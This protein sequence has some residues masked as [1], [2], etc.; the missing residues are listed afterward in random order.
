MYPDDERFEYIKLKA[1]RKLHGIERKGFKEKY[2]LGNFKHE[3]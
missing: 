3:L 1:L 2:Y